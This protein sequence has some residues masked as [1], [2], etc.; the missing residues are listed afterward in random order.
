[1]AEED[2]RHPV[3]VCKRRNNVM[4]CGESKDIQKILDILDAQKL[5]HAIKPSGSNPSADDDST[6]TPDDFVSDD[7]HSDDPESD[8][9][10]NSDPVDLCPVKYNRTKKSKN[11]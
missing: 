9:D 2:R 7:D 5:E 6:I 4:L 10:E 11:K 3:G 1:M 8:V